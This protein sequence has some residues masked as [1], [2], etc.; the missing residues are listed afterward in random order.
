M[1]AYQPNSSPEAGTIRTLGGI[2]RSYVVK[3]VMLI[4]CLA[5]VLVPAPVTTKAAGMDMFLSVSPTSVMAGEWA[6]VSAIVVNN[7]GSKVRMT[8]TFS[9]VDPCGT[10][11][12]LGYNRL[13]LN[14]G[15]SVLVT[16]AYPTSANACRGTHTITMSTGGGGKG[17]ASSTGVSTTLE[18]L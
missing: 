5:L 10:T 13:V 16:T 17:K 18:V 11:T 9:A 4:A 2:M 6:G 12:D 1:S 8:V 7:S 15:Q 14:A 3:S